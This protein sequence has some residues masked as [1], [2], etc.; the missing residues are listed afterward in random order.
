MVLLM[1]ALYDFYRG[2]KNVFQSVLLNLVHEVHLKPDRVV[3]V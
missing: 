1:G 3:D 2:T